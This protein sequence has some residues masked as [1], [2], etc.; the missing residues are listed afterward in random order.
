MLQ[1]RRYLITGICGFVGKHF[2]RFLSQNHPGCEVLGMD[3][4]PKPENLC[5]GVNNFQYVQAD[6]LDSAAVKRSLASFRPDYVLHLASVSS[7]AKS[8]EMPVESFKNNTNIFLNL[9]EIIRELNF[10]TRILSIGS[11]EEYGNYTQN[12]MPLKEEYELRPSSPYSVARVSQELLSNLYAK[13][14]GLDIV[15]TRSFNHIGPHQSD[16]FAISSFVKQLVEISRRRRENVINVGNI[17][18]IRDFLDVRDVVDIYYTLLMEGKSA[19]VYNVCSGV[20]IKLRDI[21]EKAA[22]T[23][24]I[25]VQINIDSARIRTTDATVIIGDNSK[26]RKEF[27]WTPKFTL[28]ETIKDMINCRKEDVNA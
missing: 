26:I 15:M 20:G 28:D 24:D 27:G 11:S 4:N 9:V 18:V 10:R 17:E 2:M 14:Y 8:W 12:E 25:D 23:L 5:Y 22:K 3:I 6:L 1:P 13:G 7:V 16:K 21:I 19:E